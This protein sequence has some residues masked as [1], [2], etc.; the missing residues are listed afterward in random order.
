MLVKKDEQIS[1]HTQKVITY[2]KKHQIQLK[3]GSEPNPS[4]C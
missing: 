1:A 2:K 4:L 3:K